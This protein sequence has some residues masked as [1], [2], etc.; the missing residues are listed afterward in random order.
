MGVAFV[1]FGE[2]LL[3][4]QRGKALLGPTQCCNTTSSFAFVVDT[5]PLAAS[6]GIM[7]SWLLPMPDNK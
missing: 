2:A 1:R 5:Y 4:P 3:P 7:I 6:S